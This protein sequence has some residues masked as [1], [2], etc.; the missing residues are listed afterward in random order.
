MDMD[1]KTKFKGFEPVF[2]GES[3]VLILGSFPSTRSREYGFYYGNNRNRFWGMLE[4]VFGENIGK[5]IQERKDFLLSHN[6]ALFDAVSESDLRGS[7]DSN[8]R[9]SNKTVSTLEFL[10]PPHTRVEKILCNG[11]TAFDIVTKTLNTSLPIIYMP[12]TSP[13]NIT[14][15]IVPWKDALNFLQNTRKNS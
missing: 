1:E 11:K 5:S 9:K 3:R 12:S 10:L 7:L 14:F 8:L 6:I 4:E 15:S 13:A 2:C